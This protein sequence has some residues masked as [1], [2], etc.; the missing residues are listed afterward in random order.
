MTR[1]IISVG[2]LEAKGLRRTLGEGIL[3]MSSGSLIVLKSIRHN[4]L[5]F[6]M[7]SVVIG[8]T[9]S[10]QLEGDST[11]SW[12]SKLGQVGLKSDQALGG[13]STCRLEA[14]DSGVLDKKKVKFGTDTHHLHDL[15]ELVYVDVRRPTKNASLGDHQYFVS[16]VNDYTRHCWDYPMRQ[17]GPRVVG[18]VEESIEKS[19][20]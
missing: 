4:N 11:R 16:V 7:G 15:L 3:K 2:A 1:N 8:L 6:L 10:R 5:Y 13:T 17:R 12:H 19:G 14:P 9:S 18:E 20:R